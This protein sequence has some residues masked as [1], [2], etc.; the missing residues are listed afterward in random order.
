M[1]HI[2]CCGSATINSEEEL[3]QMCLNLLYK[4]K[5]PPGG[6]NL[7]QVDNLH[8]I[9]TQGLEFD[10][11]VEWFLQTFDIGV[12]GPRIRSSSDEVTEGSC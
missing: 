11:F 7:A 10:E 4:L 5:L 9:S 1:T 6:L 12:K 8:A 2:K 3:K